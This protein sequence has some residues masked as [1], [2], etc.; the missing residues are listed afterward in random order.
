MT[1]KSHALAS[2]SGQHDAEF[3]AGKRGD[4]DFYVANVLP[5]ALAL[6]RVVAAGGDSVVA[7]ELA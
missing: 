7:A 6:A 3:A 4:C 5:Q 1:A 2:R